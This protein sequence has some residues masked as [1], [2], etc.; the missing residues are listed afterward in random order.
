MD[1]YKLLFSVMESKNKHTDFARTL[2]GL[3][4]VFMRFLDVVHSK[5]VLHMDV[6]LQN[7]LFNSHATASDGVVCDFQGAIK[8]LALGQQLYGDAW[9]T[10]LLAKCVPREATQHTRDMWH[11]VGFGKL[12]SVWENYSTANTVIVKVAQNFRPYIDFHS[13]ASSLIR[14]LLY[15]HD[16]P[17]KKSTLHK[18][19]LHAV[20]SCLIGDPRKP[21][22]T[23]ASVESMFLKI[24]HIL[25]PGQSIHDM[26]HV[27]HMW[28]S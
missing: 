4:Y 13:L 16:K 17:G 6:G 3:L 23:P 27:Q 8:R 18:Q 20:I 22:Q 25:H 21:K 5:G 24:H 15:L 1:G 14:V 7:S 28:A 19:Q 12:Y 26:K 2:Y 11:S 10:P 9:T